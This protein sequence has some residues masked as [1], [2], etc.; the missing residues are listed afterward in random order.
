MKKLNG[1]MYNNGGLTRQLPASPV[2][3]SKVGIQCSSDGICRR[4]MIARVGRS[5]KDASISVASCQV[6][7]FGQQFARY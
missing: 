7:N 2:V 1:T 5:P 3:P 6:S 4:I